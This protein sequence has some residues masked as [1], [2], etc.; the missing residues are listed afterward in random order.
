MIELTD[1]KN[2]PMLIDESKIAA[3]WS[4]QINFAPG[5]PMIDATAIRIDGIT[6][7]CK[8]TIS[9]LSLLLP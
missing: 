9:E 6:L 4:S 3:A 7:H 8:Q 2:R 1:G 5:E